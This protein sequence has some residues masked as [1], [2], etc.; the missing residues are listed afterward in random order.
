MHV[1]HMEECVPGVAHIFSRMLFVCGLDGS[2]PSLPVTFSLSANHS[3]G[4]IKCVHEGHS[5][6]D[7]LLGGGIMCV[8][9]NII[10]RFEHPFLQDYVNSLHNSSNPQDKG[11]SSLIS[12]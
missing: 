9:L 11:C 2:L 3:F 7:R 5:N 4:I 10:P 8:H 1:Q 12:T 6:Y